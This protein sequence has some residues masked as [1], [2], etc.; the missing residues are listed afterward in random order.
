MMSWWAWFLTGMAFGFLVTLNV[1][2]ISV[3]RE[4]R[5]NG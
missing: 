5:R 1:A 3:A 2:L 4:G